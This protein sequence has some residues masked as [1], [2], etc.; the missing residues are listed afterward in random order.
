MRH[1]TKAALDRLTIGLA[2]EVQEHNLAVNS[3]SPGLVITE[4]ARLF[5]PGRATWDGWGD[6]ASAPGAGCAG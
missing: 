1:K 5:N 4:G 3:L 2:S 6:F